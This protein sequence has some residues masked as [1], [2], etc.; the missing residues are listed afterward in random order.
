MA[1]KKEAKKLQ[2]FGSFFTKPLK[3][4]DYFTPDEVR[5]IVEQ[6]AQ[7]VDVPDDDHI[8][9]LIDTAL[10]VIENGTY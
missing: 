8:N 1:D 4:V 6:S 3:G 10:G 2:V 7:L 5:D 9:S